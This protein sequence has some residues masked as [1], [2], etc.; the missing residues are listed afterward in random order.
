MARSDLDKPWQDLTS[1]AIAALPA[2]LG[3]Y[4]VADAAGT[5]TH[6]GYAGGRET[7]GI[8]T[9]LEREL[10][11][12]GVRFRH[13]LTHGYMTRWHELLMAHQAR[14]GV[15]PEGNLGDAHRIGRLSP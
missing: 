6:I 14:T 1:T 8:R 4:E 12:G 13:E 3:V 9:A 11:A 7:F 5:V 15:L 2:Q 10:A